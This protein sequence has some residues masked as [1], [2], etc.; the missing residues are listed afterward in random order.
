MISIILLDHIEIEGNEIMMMMKMIS[1][2]EK[3]IKIVER[4]EN[5][6]N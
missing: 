4:N 3:I 6:L 5:K 2:M 1:M